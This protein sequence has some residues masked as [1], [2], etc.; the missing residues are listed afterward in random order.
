M[1][2]NKI[3]LVTGGSRGLGKNMA[4]RLA[5][6]GNDIIITYHSKKDEAEAVVVEILEM[7]HKAIALQL[8]VSQT[9]TFEPFF[10][11]VETVL[12]K[13]KKNGRT[14]YLVKYL[15]W[16]KK[17]NAWVDETDLKDIQEND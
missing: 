2:K 5:E 10:S 16:D 17:Y 9:K 4:I 6:A 13:R 1:T 12:K 15:G 14:Q 8:D 3:A 11:E 7:G